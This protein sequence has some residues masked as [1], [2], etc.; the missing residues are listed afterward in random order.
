[1]RSQEFSIGLVSAI[2]ELVV[3]VFGA[4]EGSSIIRGRLMNRKKGLPRSIP[5][6]LVTCFGYENW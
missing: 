3:V 1:M 6:D 4:A 5:K 2:S